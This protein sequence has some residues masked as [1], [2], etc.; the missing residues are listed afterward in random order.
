[1]ADTAA[2][3]DGS[4]TAT[5]TPTGSDSGTRTG[6]DS[7][8]GTGSDSGTRTGSDSGTGTGTGSGSGTGAGTGAAAGT[9][10]APAAP[11]T[12]A[13]PAAA[14]PFEALGATRPRIRRDVLF[15]ETPGG[16]LFHNADGGFHLTGRTAYRFASLV[17]PHL[18]GHH[19]L[20]EL[21][22]GFGPAQRAMAAELVRTLY[23]RSF[24]RD[25]P[26][27]D[28]TAPGATG[29]DEAVHR[30]FAAQI[31]YV[32]HYADAAPERFA[33]FR[34]TR[35]A[36]LG[37]DETAR[38]CAL[39]LVRNGCARVGVA[40]DF[41]DVTAEA[42]EAEADG[43]PVRV[44]RLGADDGWTALA[45]WDV[46][47]VT[48]AGAAARTHRLLAAGVPE[49]RT[50]IPA[51]TFGEHRVTG[52][53]STAATAGCWSCAALRLGAG[54]DAGAAAADLW[55]EVAGVL[56]DAASPL[57][58]PV[59]AMS[60]NLLGYEV[61]RVTTGALPAETDGQV[62]LQD[63]RSLDVVAEPVHPHPRCVRCAGRTPAG[64]DGAP[65]AALALPATPSVDT[66]RE[67]EAVVD[68]LNR[69]SAALV[70]P[71]AGVFT[72]YADEEITQ[73]PLKVSR[74]ELAVGH[75]RRRTVAAFDVHHLAGARTRALYAAAEV[76]TE[77]VVPPAA[78]AAAGTGARLAPDA[79]TT[80]GGTGT[81]ADA[82]TAWTTATSLLTKETVAVPAA[83]VRALGALND[84]R[85]HLATGAGTGAGPGPQEAA[86]RG[87][88]SA[89][90]H[91]ALLRAVS[92][93]TRV[94][95]VGAPDDDP[96]L[97]FLLTSAG[98][99]DIAAELLDLGEDERSS[100][101]AVLARETGGDGRWALG[102]GLSRRDAACE[103][104][105]DLLG[106]VQLAAEDPEYAYDPGLP[107]V[108]DLAPG[109][110]AVTEPGPCPP[111]ARATA[112]D[113]VLDRLRA[114]G[115]DVLHV[116]T[117][118]A[119]L[120]A[121]GISTARVLLTTGPGTAAM[122]PS[123]PSGAPGADAAAP[124]PSGGADAAVSPA[125]AATAPGGAN[126]A[127]A[128]AGSGGEAAAVSGATAATASG[129]PAGVT[130]AHPAAPTATP[131]ATPGS[132]DDER[133]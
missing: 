109:T 47:V 105:R 26:E 30:R 9:D 35:V 61:F 52:P 50:L 101:Y 41:A 99:L 44:D 46:V 116:A 20:A 32:D 94:T 3:V 102:A 127:G 19:T 122:P 33:R 72:R 60:G 5:R 83:A 18:T 125:T 23:A 63:L 88:L 128:P 119:D 76:Y 67:A 11:A 71:H 48:G 13:A 49:G 24:A 74:V 62:L 16:V 95:P 91:D 40:A 36:V 98:T 75:G 65:P 89:L 104:L 64:P 56:P 130:P 51:W 39:S 22:A 123:D 82:V 7:G 81:A 57:T 17:V 79:L 58:G 117:T 38:W 68:D 114:A 85:L 110:V 87:L 45:D 54:P 132:G 15:T 59:A 27:A 126:P 29:A 4:T 90:A 12:G 115:R 96:E 111:T 106:Q 121:C 84:D 28:L 66:A 77:H 120:A 34:G 133:R 124:V 97:A 6:S 8:T 42:A 1:M 103:A 107:L 80:G 25:V 113:T 14:D 86:G 31:A 21:C 129:A 73:T 70:R 131:A 43:C 100:A 53:L 37:G 69:I 108:G 78:E 2:Q 92:G 93:T 112:F 55:A 118:P 10:P